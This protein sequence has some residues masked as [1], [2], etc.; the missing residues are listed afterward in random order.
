M[1][2]Y[3][4]FL[5][6]FW[7]IILVTIGGALVIVP[8]AKTKLM[9]FL[10]LKSSRWFFGFLAFSIGLFHITLHNKWQT[11]NEILISMFGWSAFVKGIILFTFPN[12]IN[13]SKKVMNS[14]LFPF[15]IL[16]CI[17]LGF[18]LLNE[19]FYLNGLSS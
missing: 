12:V 3:T 15:I 14:I 18:Y 1:E 16:F 6:T 17:I 19:S 10:E 9:A 8:I 11:Q 7:G 13:I 4:T 2:D 5:M